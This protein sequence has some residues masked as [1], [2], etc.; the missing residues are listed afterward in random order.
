MPLPHRGAALRASILAIPLA[1]AA[2]AVPAAGLE[3]HDARAPAPPPGA[4]VM[5]GYLALQNSGSDAVTV[6]GGAS[7]AFARIALHRSVDRDGTT[8]MEPVER[9]R[10]GPGERVELMPGGLHLMMFEPRGRP[11]PG[12][13]FELRLHTGAGPVPVR[14][15]VIERDALMDHGG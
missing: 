10:V 12:D 3:V 5:A 13:T 1:L 11:R 14:M 6:T 4:P 9:L 15:R 2:A 8:T 7:P